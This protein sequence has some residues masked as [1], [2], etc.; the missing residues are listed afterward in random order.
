MLELDEMTAQSDLILDLQTLNQISQTLNQSTDVHT[1]L[2]TSLAQLVDL[3]GM[4]TGWVFVREEAATR[5]ALIGPDPDAARHRAE[6]L[7]SLIHRGGTE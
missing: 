1:A 5:L 4:E 6:L 2:N 7:A 3:M